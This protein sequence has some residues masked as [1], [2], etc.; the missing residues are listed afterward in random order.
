MDCPKCGGSGGGDDPALRCNLC[1]GTGHVEVP[2]CR[3]CGDGKDWTTFAVGGVER[4]EWVCRRCL[5]DDLVNL[6]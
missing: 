3:D 4:G 6:S 1:H 5:W 2:R